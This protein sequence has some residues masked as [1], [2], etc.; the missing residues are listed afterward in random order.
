MTTL[1]GGAVAPAPGAVPTTWKKESAWGRSTTPSTLSGSVPES[2][3]AR[4]TLPGPALR[5]AAVCC[6]IK[7]PRCAPSR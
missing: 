3:W 5:L 7:T 2:V 6:W 1:S 4:I